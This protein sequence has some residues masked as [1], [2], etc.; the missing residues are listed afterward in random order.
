MTTMSTDALALIATYMREHTP[1]PR[2][3]LAVLDALRT[4]RGA[5]PWGGCRR[6]KGWGGKASPGRPGRPLLIPD[7]DKLT[8]DQLEIVFV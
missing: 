3:P 8:D 5:I 1:A 7:L 6:V 2:L 4:I